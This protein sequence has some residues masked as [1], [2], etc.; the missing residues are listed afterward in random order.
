MPLTLRV[1]DPIG[2]ARFDNPELVLATGWYR[3]RGSGRSAPITVTL[4]RDETAA[5]LIH[6]ELCRQARPAFPDADFHVYRFGR[7]VVRTFVQS[8]GPSAEALAAEISRLGAPDAHWGTRQPPLSEH[9]GEVIA[10]GVRLTRDLGGVHGGKR[11]VFART[12]TE[13]VRLLAMI[14]DPAL[15]SRLEGVSM[16]RHTIVLLRDVVELDQI[17]PARLFAEPGEEFVSNEMEHRLIID[18]GHASFGIAT[19]LTLER[20][21]VTPSGVTLKAPNLKEGFIG[22]PPDPLP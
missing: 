2:G 3:P 21:P 6:V 14:D 17:R 4:C 20:L 13:R 7:L 12:P 16:R 10:T 22:S 5:Q 15:R 11:A 9:A 18:A 8:D 19:V 1:M